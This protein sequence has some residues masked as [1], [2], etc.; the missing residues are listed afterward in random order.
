MQ[1]D[2]SQK[3]KDIGMVRKS[4]FHQCNRYNEGKHILTLARK[5]AEQKQTDNFLQISMTI[6]AIIL[7]SSVMHS[8]WLPFVE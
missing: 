1:F 3:Y 4:L 8:G 2:E 6:I 7:V 5:A